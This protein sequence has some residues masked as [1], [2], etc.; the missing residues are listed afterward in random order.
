MF[1]SNLSILEAEFRPE[2]LLDRHCVLQFSWTTFLCKGVF[3]GVSLECLW[4]ELKMWQKREGSYIYS[5]GLRLWG[6]T[7]GGSSSTLGFVD[8]KRPTDKLQDVRRVAGLHVLQVLLL[9]VV[10]LLE[11][12][13]T[14]KT[15]AWVV[16]L[17]KKP[18]FCEASKM[19]KHMPLLFSS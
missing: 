18:L 11:F 9:R 5:V 2:F 19:Q 12:W 4:L 7:M 17:G 3:R 1:K 14:L 16:L 6:E 10:L 15:R 8:L 13:W